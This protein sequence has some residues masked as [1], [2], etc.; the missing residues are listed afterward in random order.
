MEKDRTVI[1]K[2]ISNMLDNPDK[3]GI[4]PTSTC[5]TSLELYI[6]Q[7]RIEALGWALADA[8]IFLDQ[9]RDPRTENVP[10]ILKRALE[11]LS[12]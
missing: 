11:D 10:G 3:S 8:C 4:Y 2:I 12:K 6:E 5:Y 1:C 7:V 9:G